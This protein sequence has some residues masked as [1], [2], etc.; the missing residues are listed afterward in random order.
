LRLARGREKLRGLCTE[1]LRIQM[2]WKTFLI[3]LA[4][5]PVW[6]L[7][8]AALVYYSAFAAAQVR[9][10]YWAAYKVSL[11]VSV[12]RLCWSTLW[13]SVLYHGPDPGSVDIVAILFAL[14][15]S[16]LI[17]AASYGRGIIATEGQPIG[18]VKGIWVSFWVD[19][20]TLWIL[21]ALLAVAMSLE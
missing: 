8:F 20:S 19:F 15:G 11:F 7:L 16:F 5:A 4:G 6:A 9:V 17:S 14:I 18:F 1:A 2:E 13:L 21:V 10:P 12:A 3:G